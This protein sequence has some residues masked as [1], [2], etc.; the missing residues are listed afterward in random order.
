MSLLDVVTLINKNPDGAI[1]R[2]Q[3]SK[4][5]QP[6]RARERWKI[7][8]ELNRSSLTVQTC[9]AM[10]RVIRGGRCLVDGDSPEGVAQVGGKIGERTRSPGDRR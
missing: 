4:A 6:G 5:G 9:P 10:I 1:Q 2:R 3:F 8:V 7:S